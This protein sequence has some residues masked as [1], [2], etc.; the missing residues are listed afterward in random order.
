VKKHIR[1]VK[2]LF[3]RYERPIA[4]GSLLFGF[5]V[6]LLTLRRIDLISNQLILIG[7]L[8]VLGTG[9]ALINYY[10]ISATPPRWLEKWY[11]YL[12]VIIQFAFGNMFSGF[13]VLY[14]RSTSLVA[15][16]PFLLLLLGL[17]LGNELFQP[18]YLRFRFQS[19]LFF[20]TLFSFFIVYVPLLSGS[21]DPF[22]FLLSAAV[23]VAVFLLFLRALSWKLPGLV[24]QNRKSIVSIMVSIV[25]IISL[26]YFTNLIP[27]IPLSLEESGA[28]H[29]VRKVP[30]GYVV[31]H[32][33]GE[34]PGLLRRLFT[35][36]TLHLAPG[37]GAYL[38]SS[39]F[40]P[41][42]FS[43]TVV[44]D[45]QWYDEA[46]GKWVSLSHIP[47]TVSG[48]RTEG[49]RGYSV[50]SA[51]PDGRWR[52]EIETEGGQVI[53]RVRFDVQHVATV[54]LLFESVR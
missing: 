37:E 3:I 1:T 46:K 51:V 34:A 27:P 38:F 32:E 39:V 12:P 13:M 50:K 2:E 22:T 24:A 18:Y 36:T 41:T 28:Y 19:A 16:W 9:I 21:I 48:G 14:S 26:F 25:A 31:L 8:L 42:R 40:A 44:H 7:Y 17:L 52:V 10:Q 33:R 20:F 15:N 29:G 49:Y 6:D 4:S 11:I 47:F 43:T 35:T 5:I 45:W 23:A 54:P 30:N 53:G